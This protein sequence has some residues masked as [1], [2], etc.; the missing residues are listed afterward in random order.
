[1]HRSLAKKTT[2][3][4]NWISV[5]E[6]MPVPSKFLGSKMYLIRFAE[7]LYGTA[8]YMKGFKGK[9][10]NDDLK[11]DGF[12]TLNGNGTYNHYRHVTHWAEITDPIINIPTKNRNKKD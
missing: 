3:K 2:N 1:M 4:T 8:R 6:R 12:R 10:T 7:N 11:K 9:Y 5:E